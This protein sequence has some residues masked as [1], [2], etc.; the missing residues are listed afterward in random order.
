LLRDA[1]AVYIGTL[2]YLTIRFI[3]HLVR[4][5]WRQAAQWS[6]LFHSAVSR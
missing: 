1:I 5:A 3:L 6:P 2:F 4:F